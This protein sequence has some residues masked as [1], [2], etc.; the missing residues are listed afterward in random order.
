M[1]EALH[2]IISAEQFT[3]EQ[4]DSVFARAS[5]LREAIFDLAYRRELSERYKGAIAINLFYQPSTRTRTSFEVAQACLGIMPITTESARLFSSAAKGETL[6]DTIRVES[7]YP[8]DLIVLRHDKKGGAAR[9]AAVSRVPIINGGD[10]SGE[11]PTQALLD[12][13]TIK[14]QLDRLDGLNVVMGGDLRYGR[15]VRSLAYVLSKYHGNKITFVSIPELQVTD[16]IKQK[17]RASGTSFE[18]TDDMHEAFRHADV[19]YWTRLQLENIQ[20]KSRQRIVKKLLGMNALFDTTRFNIGK[21]DLVYL[22]PE[23]IILHPLPRVGE[24]ETEVDQDP[25]AKYF[26]QAGNGPII[27]IPLIDDVL[28]YNY[29]QAA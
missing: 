28:E 29:T 6:E 26:R 21:K 3:V 5:E 4:M 15:T 14:E 24:I 13:F 8:I 16:D 7:E 1:S 27:R 9:A 18:E 23:S 22:P 19:V 2:H 25:R 12:A 10:G 11:H 17:L 20:L